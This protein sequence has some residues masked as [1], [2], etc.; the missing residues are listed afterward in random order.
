MTSL[1]IRELTDQT[2]KQETVCSRYDNAIFSGDSKK[3]RFEIMGKSEDEWSFIPK[4]IARQ[5]RM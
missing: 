4:Q 1:D 5:G 2:F 3:P